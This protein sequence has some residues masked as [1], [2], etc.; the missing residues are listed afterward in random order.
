MLPVLHIGSLSIRTYPIACLLAIFII[1]SYS[2]FRLLRINPSTQFVGVRVFWVLLGG[3]CGAYLP[4]LIP[5][6]IRFLRT[7]NRQWAGKENILIGL[8]CAFI[9]TILLKAKKGPLGKIFDAAFLPVPLGLMIARLGCLFAGCCYGSTTDSALGMYLPGTNG[10]WDYRYPTQILSA[11]ANLFIFCFLCIFERW[12][13]RQ[14]TNGKPAPFDGFLFLL[15]VI[16]YCLKRFIIQFMRY[17]YAP[18][19]GAIDWPQIITLTGIGSSILII[20]W[21]LHRPAHIQS[22]QS[23]E[24]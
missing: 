14:V 13:N 11:I 17:D 20:A 6:L 10:I 15:F 24:V 16:L 23:G 18:V 4:V 9:L 19:L 2:Y 21:N 5:T 1:G 12:K 8:A 3:F 7:G 22:T